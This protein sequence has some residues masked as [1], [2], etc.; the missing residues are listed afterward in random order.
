MTG[1]TIRL[2]GLSDAPAV[3]EQPRVSIQQWRVMRLATAGDVLV[4]VQDGVLATRVSTDLISVRAAQ[5]EVTTVS[6][7]VYE[8]MGPPAN[9]PD[10]LVLL[11]ARVVV[12]SGPIVEDV[13]PQYWA[14][15]QAA[16]P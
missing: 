16:A 12:S 4:G 1:R 3:A 14:L 15:I 7:R 2:T 6:G 9:N 5:R 13:T 10:M 11:A 8:L